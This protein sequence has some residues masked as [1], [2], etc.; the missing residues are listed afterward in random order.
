MKH[1]DFDFNGRTY[2]LSFTAEALFTVYDKFGV[3][4]NILAE[5]KALE[6]S[7]EGWKNCCYLAALMASQ[8]ELQRRRQGYD[9]QPMLSVEELRT[10]FMAAESTRLR[11]AVRTALE[12][13]FARSV[14]DHDE[15][16]EIDLVLREREMTQKK[17][18]RRSSPRCVPLRLRSELPPQPRRRPDALPGDVF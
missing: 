12:Q 2:A 8:G 14:E 10:G 18:W 13:G 6:P 15:D 9:P 7:A 16:K 11:Q 1:I 4:D 3:T 17:R 5:T